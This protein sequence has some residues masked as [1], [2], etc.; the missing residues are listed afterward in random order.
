M[1]RSR[2]AGNTRRVRLNFFLYSFHT[3]IW[4]IKLGTEAQPSPVVKQI[5]S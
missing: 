1:T 3:G 5:N 2:Y 4:V